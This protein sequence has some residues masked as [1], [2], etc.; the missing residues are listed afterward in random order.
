MALKMVMMRPAFI[1]FLPPYGIKKLFLSTY[2]IT[3]RPMA[4]KAYLGAFLKKFEST[5]QGVEAAGIESDVI[6]FDFRSTANSG[7][8]NNPVGS[9][10]CPP[11][12][13]KVYASSPAIK[14][15]ALLSRF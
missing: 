5:G 12:N 14:H 7:E 13:E 2:R 4:Y 3:Q 8:S 10:R 9:V 11:S 6:V 15:N 1:F